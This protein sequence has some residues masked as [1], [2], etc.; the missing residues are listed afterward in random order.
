MQW[1]R[2]FNSF[3]SQSALTQSLLLPA[4]LLTALARALVLIVPF[5]RFSPYL[6]R[7]SGVAPFLPLATPSQQKTALAIGRAI[8]MAA[9]FTHWEA[10]C[11][12][13]AIS[14]RCFL[15]LFSVPYAVFYGVAH[16]PEQAMRAHAWVC[17][18]PVQV[19][20]GYAFDEFTVVA[21]F[22]RP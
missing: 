8:R 14:A 12:A 21:V 11:Q 18:G 5:K 16:A 7:H 2:K 9:Q 10:N 15:G 1:R 17:T 22:A 13:Q 20:G 19:T 4:W 6:G 3:L